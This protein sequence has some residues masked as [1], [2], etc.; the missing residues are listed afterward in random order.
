M[1]PWLPVSKPVVL[2]GV[3]AFMPLSRFALAPLALDWNRHR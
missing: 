1:P 2:L 3:A